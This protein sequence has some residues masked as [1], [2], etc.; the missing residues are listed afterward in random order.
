MQLDDLGAFLKQ[1]G[2]ESVPQ[3][4]ATRFDPGGRGEAFHLLLNGLDRESDSANVYSHVIA[5]L[6]IHA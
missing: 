6:A 2:S 3:R 5:G 4:M 1:V